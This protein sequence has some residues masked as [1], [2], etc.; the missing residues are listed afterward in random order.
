MMNDIADSPAIIFQEG[1]FN[2]CIVSFL[3]FKTDVRR[4]ISFFTCDVQVRFVH[5]PCAR[6]TSAIN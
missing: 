1:V 6:W 5:R 2:G 4:K 3:S